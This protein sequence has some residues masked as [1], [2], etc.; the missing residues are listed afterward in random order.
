MSCGNFSVR[1]F[2]QYTQKSKK[3]DFYTPPHVKISMFTECETRR[4]EKKRG[5]LTILKDFLKES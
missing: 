3:H 1:N 5:F 4:K 2:L